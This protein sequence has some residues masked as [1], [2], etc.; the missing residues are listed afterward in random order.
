MSRKKKV[1][2]GGVGMDISVDMYRLGATLY[3][4]LQKCPPS[5]DISPPQ[6]RQGLFN[7]NFRWKSLSVSCR[8]LLTSLLSFHPS[9]RP[10]NCQQVL[11]H[12]WFNESS[13]PSSSTVTMAAS[14]ATATATAAGTTAATTSLPGAAATIGGGSGDTV[15]SPPP[16]SIPLLS[17]AF[18]KVVDHSISPPTTTTQIDSDL[19]PKKRKFM[20][21][22]VGLPTQGTTEVVTKRRSSRRTNSQH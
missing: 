17:G 6:R 18:P 15:P 10:K 2:A 22:Q 8:D 11:K 3:T 1:Y 21:P 20:I 4:A 19:V 13:D 9:D 7:T 5:Q 14:I 16:S 12:P